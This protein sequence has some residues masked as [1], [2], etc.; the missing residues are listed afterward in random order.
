MKLLRVLCVTTI[1]RWQ[2]VS[3]GATWNEEEPSANLARTAAANG[4]FDVLKWLE[5]QGQVDGVVGLVLSAVENGHVE[6]VQW[7][8]N[9]DAPGY[10]SDG[11]RYSSHAPLTGLGGEAGLSIHIA[12]ENGHLKIEKYLRARILRITQR[13]TEL[14]KIRHQF[15]I[16]QPRWNKAA[17]VS[18]RR[19][20]KAAR[21]GHLDVVKWLYLEYGDGSEINIFDNC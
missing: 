16:S 9:R 2:N 17:K 12:A 10:D 19:M 3:N 13:V 15:Q 5:S 1:S 7:L 14:E 4:Q 21:N 18:G 6:T 11:K 20:T 8:I